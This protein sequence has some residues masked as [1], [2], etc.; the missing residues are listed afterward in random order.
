MAA[1]APSI[2]SPDIAST[3]LASETHT[4]SPDIKV[5]YAKNAKALAVRAGLS[6]FIPVPP[7][8]SLAINTA[9]T[10][11]IANIHNGI[12][13]G[14]IIGIRRPVTRYPSLTG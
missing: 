5:G 7:K 14:I 4:L 10:T 1:R 6:I 12:S 3:L 13:I 8:A 2:V 9:K 11:E